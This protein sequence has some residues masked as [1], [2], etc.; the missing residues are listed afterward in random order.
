MLYGTGIRI[1]EAIRLTH[2]DI[3]L[4]EG[5]LILRDCKNGQDRIVP[6][7]ISL[8][9]VCKDYIAYKQSLGLNT[10]PDD[11]FFTSADGKICAAGNISVLFRMIL[12]RAGI[13]RGKRGESPRLH[14]LR[15][16]FCV[17]ALVQMSEA[18]MDLYYS[19]PVLMTYMGHKSL[20]ATN[21]Y[22]R[23]TEEMFP[24]LIRKVNEAYIIRVPRNKH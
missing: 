2:R 23:I 18:N 5:I 14:D 11:P 10:E 16:T 20:S 3:N 8:K 21:R 17:N 22:V 6:I 15:H 13:P 7:S 4:S 12:Y 19:M 9:E 1:G 24:G